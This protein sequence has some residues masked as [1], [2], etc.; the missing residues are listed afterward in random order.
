[1]WTE[2]LHQP[3]R[4][5]LWISCNPKRPSIYCVRVLMKL[6]AAGYVT[7]VVHVVHTCISKEHQI[8]VAYNFACFFHVD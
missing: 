7:Y 3:L 2:A 4:F 8:T 1:M 6:D 5:V